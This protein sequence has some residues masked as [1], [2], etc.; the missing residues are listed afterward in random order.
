[1]RSRSA[2]GSAM[3]LHVPPVATERLTL[4]PLAPLYGRTERAQRIA[5]SRDPRSDPDGLP[6]VCSS[7]CLVAPLAEAIL[8]T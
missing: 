2:S 5:A 4:K 1:M 3:P 7:E 8:A 6:H